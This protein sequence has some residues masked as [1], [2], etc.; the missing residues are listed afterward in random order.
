MSRREL[1]APGGLWKAVVGPLGPQQLQGR[2]CGTDAGPACSC[3]RCVLS[4]PPCLPVAGLALVP[5]KLCVPTTPGGIPCCFRPGRGPTVPPAARSRADG[6]SGE[7]LRGPLHREISGHTHTCSYTHT[8]PG[9][10]VSRQ[11]L[12]LAPPDSLPDLPACLALPAPFSFESTTVP[13]L[14]S[15]KL[16]ALE[17]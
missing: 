2:P 5:Q 3:E 11:A 13:N 15:R 7:C 6:S 12:P 16:V 8:R 17:L 10:E 9:L 4:D 14:M 1:G